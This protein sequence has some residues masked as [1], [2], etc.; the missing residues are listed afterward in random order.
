[1]SRRTLSFVTALL[2]LVTTAGFALR[3]GGVT[4]LVIIYGVMAI[5]HSWSA[6]GNWDN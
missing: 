2:M 5:L 4:I 3:D 6:I 1:M